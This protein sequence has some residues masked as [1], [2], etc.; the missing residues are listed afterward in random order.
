SRLRARKRERLREVEAAEAG[1]H[2]LV[3]I[4]GHGGRPTA[5]PVYFSA[6]ELVAGGRVIGRLPLGEP[7]SDDVS[8]AHLQS[9]GSA[10]GGVT[11]WRGKTARPM[12][13]YG[14]P[15]HKV[16]GVFPVE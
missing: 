9:E 8:R 6:I 7:V 11:E 13:N 1:T 15:F 14:S 16:A 3:E 10:W 2:V 12:L 5:A 4:A